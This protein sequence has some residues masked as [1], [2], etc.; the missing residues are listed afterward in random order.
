[1]KKNNSPEKK[2]TKIPVIE[3][4]WRGK[5]VKFRPDRVVI[6]LKVV[7]KEKECGFLKDKCKDICKLVPDAKIFRYPKKMPIF[8]LRVPE[9]SNVVELAEKISKRDDVVYAEPDFIGTIGIVPDDTRYADQ[10]GPQKINSEGAWDLET[11]DNDILIGIIDTGFATA[12]DGTLNHPDLDDAARYILGTDF[13]NDDNLPRDDHSHGTHVA[14]IAAAMSNNTE[15]VVGMN[16]NSPVYICKVFDSAGSGS[17]SDVEAAVEEIVD[18][19][20]DNNLHVVINL[21]AR[22][23]SGHSA[24]RDAAEY[25]HDNGM[26]FCIATG[27]DYDTSVGFPAAYSSDFDGVIAVG[28]TDDDDTVSSFSN[29]GPEI[30]LVAPGRDILATTP[31][32]AVTS[33]DTD[34]DEKTGTSMACPHVAGLASLVW[35]RESKQ[36]N[37]QVKDV[38]INTAKKLGAGNFDNSWGYG[39]VDAEEAVAKSGWDIDLPYNSL[40][41]IDIPENETTARAIRFN[42]KSFHA[43]NFEI[44]DGPTGVFEVTFQPDTSMG[45][46]TDYDT[47]RDAYIWISYTGTNVGDT[48]DGTVRVRCIETE[49]EWELT[50]TANTIARP[51]SCVMMVFDK[52]NSMSFDSGIE[53]QR[54][55]D[56]LRY[57]ANIL[58]DVIQE[59]NGMGI[60]AFDQDPHNVLIPVVG[61]LGEPSG[62]DPDRSNIRTSINTF[63]YNPSGVTSIGDGIERAST[64]LSPVAGYDNKAIVVL[65][66]GEENEEKYISEVS[67]LI[68]EKVFAVGLGTAANINPNALTEVCNNT[69]GY[70]LLTDQLDNDSYFKLAKYFLQILA[71]ITNED[72][73]VDPDGWINQG[74][75]HKIPFNLNE[76]DI[77]TDII[78]MMPYHDLIDLY[79]ETPDGTIVD[80]SSP[81]VGLYSGENVRFYRVT[82]P[83]PTM[84]GSSAHAGKW[85]AVLKFNSKYFKRYLSSLDKYP[86]AYNAAKT[87]GAQY[88][89]LVH[90]YSNLRMRCAL[91]Q[92]SYEPG[93]N[94]NLRATLTEYGVPIRKSASVK[95]EL[96]FPDNSTTNIY[97]HEIQQGIYETDIIANQSGVYQFRVMADGFTHRNT[98]YTRELVLTG[99]T[100]KGGD[101]PF[102]ESGDDPDNVKRTLCEL[103]S[104]LGKNMSK[105]LHDRL[106]KNGLNLNG[107]IKCLCYEKKEDKF[108]SVES[109]KFNK[110][111]LSQFLRILSEEVK[112]G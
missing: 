9:K 65:T 110:V 16:W 71:G 74:E 47:V 40:D 81:T 11:G 17:Q 52:S 3:G 43:T 58:V 87:H 98:R 97:L 31:T 59:G 91:S 102:P 85:H 80:A 62:I 112:R 28:S 107:L 4:E 56:V 94:I 22:W 63:N 92:N 68:N 6:K 2:P 10:W 35:S 44:I 42:V 21:S 48:H 26:I 89:L 41:F 72:V 5:K 79:L 67:D 14:G 95:A 30:T 37:E 1:M 90:A 88:T 20:I 78:L 108:R 53:G 55:I 24:L 45:K 86:K 109:L 76:A 39:R 96:T 77:S 93:A 104:C 8:V 64:Q 27:N 54:R 66:D 23:I 7:K 100:W 73:V 32:Y 106:M 46:S 70:T 50:I 111:E 105:E 12:N 38:L 25:A 13:V 84:G 15:G 99:T 51:S 57:S 69:G 83:S 19:A 49:Q 18:Y 33:G 36:T 61:P 103:I 75:V 82:L 29:T 34:Y 60:V 101:L